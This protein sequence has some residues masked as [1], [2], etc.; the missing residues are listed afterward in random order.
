MED[1]A[2]ARMQCY[3]PASPAAEASHSA[4]SQPHQS[5]VDILTQEKREIEAGEARAIDSALKFIH[6][7]KKERGDLPSINDRTL[8]N[9]Q[10]PQALLRSSQPQSPYTSDILAEESGD[11]PSINDRIPN[12]RQKQQTLLRSSQP[13]SPYTSQP[14]S[15]SPAPK[16]PAPKAPVLLAR[17]NLKEPALDSPKLSASSGQSTRPQS[18]SSFHDTPTHTSQNT[19]TLGAT[20][21]A[22]NAPRNQPAEG[23]SAVQHAMRQHMR[24]AGLGMRVKETGD[25]RVYINYLTPGGAAGAAD[26]FLKVGDHVISIDG[27]P[28]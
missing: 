17:P 20:P 27:K 10:N 14:Q 12:I 7:E 16:A 9:R 24:V 26:P 19:S 6:A 2:R 3:A 21:V 8:N 28:G 22:A 18:S 1:D 5:L 13:P 25:G 23:D 4:V 11:L 15:S